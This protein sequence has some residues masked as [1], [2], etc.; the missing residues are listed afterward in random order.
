M[1]L[2]GLD[3]IKSTKTA[4]RNAVIAACEEY[5]NGGF[6]AEPIVYG[7]FTAGNQGRYSWPP[8]SPG[9]A[10]WKAGG[11]MKVAGGVGFLNKAGRK[12]LAAFKAKIDTRRDMDPKV[13][14][15]INAEVN[16]KVQKEAMKLRG[17]RRGSKKDG[18]QKGGLPM[19]VLTGKLRDNITAG[20]AVIRQVGPESFTITWANIPKYAIYHHTGDG[21][22]K[23]SPI[24]PNEADR[25]AFLDAATRHLRAAMGMLGT[26]PAGG[27]PGRVPRGA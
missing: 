18:G 4:L 3:R 23:R 20:R 14:K 8:L 19:L 10:A 1:D 11:T 5:A 21:V 27:P 22:P 7:H 2:S 16:A 9:Y 13:Q 25:K 12:A 15:K 17:F 26:V 24:A 6:R